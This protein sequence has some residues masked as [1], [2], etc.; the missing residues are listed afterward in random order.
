MGPV[1]SAPEKVWC[2]VKARAAAEEQGDCACR[3]PHVVV[4]GRV[5][6]VVCVWLHEQDD[7]PRG[8]LFPWHGE[9]RVEGQSPMV[10][11]VSKHIPSQSHV[12]SG[13]MPEAATWPAAAGKGGFLGCHI[14]PETL[15]LFL[16]LG[17]AVEEQYSDRHEEHEGM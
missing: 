1:C 12:G 16:V 17:G 3:M 13:R 9:E 2:A 5:R 4:G 11:V 15:L 8:G 14:R 6:D 10:V 7:R